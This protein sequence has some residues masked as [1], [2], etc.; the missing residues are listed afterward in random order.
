MHLPGG[1]FSFWPGGTTANSNP[2]ATVYATHFLVNARL[3]GYVVADRV[4]D[5]SLDRLAAIARSPEGPEFRYSGQNRRLEVRAYATYVLALAGKPEKG[6]MENLRQDSLAQLP[7]S[8]RYHLAGAYGL[9]GNKSFGKVFAAVRS[10]I[11]S[12]T[13]NTRM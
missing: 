6:A 4:I 10:V 12:P 3:E 8:A 2:W 9:S 11:S 13:R 7:M 5:D 1:G